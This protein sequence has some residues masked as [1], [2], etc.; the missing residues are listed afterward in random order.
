MVTRVFPPVAPY[1]VAEADSHGGRLAAA[2]RLVLLAARAGAHAVKFSLAPAWSRSSWRSLR[3]DAARQG[4]AVIL[5]PRDQANLALARA[6]APAA[7]Q[8]D[9]PALGDLALLGRLGRE[10]RP[11]LLVAGRC[12]TLTIRRAM[13]AIG[14]APV[15][16]VHTV[17]ADS[18]APAD[19]RLGYVPWLATRFRKPVGYRGVEPGVGWAF[20]AAAIGASVI[21]K[22]LTLDGTVPAAGAP[23]GVD[24]AEL[25]V[26]AAGL[27]DLA[28]AL[29]R[30]GDRRVLPQEL[31]GVE[32]TSR[33]LVARRALKTGRVLSA[34][35]LVTADTSLG[36]AP[37]LSAW[38]VGRRLAYD[39]E[40]GEPI[41]FG[42]VDRPAKARP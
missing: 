11:V 12:T 18:V 30:V 16:V 37:H 29:G 17:A 7:Y 1:L 22:P 26:I 6:L 24:A 10:R 32:R 28:G 23:A 40:A 42:L 4:L 38:L 3:R 25:G 19:A 36:L 5:A 13:R 34:G 31:A 21:E 2:R 14:G 41:T 15:V 39:V 35:D 20:V 27:R 33:G 8:V 9:P